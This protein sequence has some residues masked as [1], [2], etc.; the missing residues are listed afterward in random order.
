MAEST[1]KKHLVIIGG[2]FGGLNLAK[3]VDKSRW[4]V[5]L[6]DRNNYHSFP[7][8]FYQV[9]SSGL[10]PASISFPFRRELNGRNYEGCSF[11]MGTVE[12][13]DVNAKTV[14][15]QYETIPYDK[16]VI[17]AG[18]TNNFFGIE[19]LEKTVF[20]LKSTT[21]AIRARNEVLDRLERAAIIPDK[22]KRAHLLTFVV[23]GGGPA[24]V[25]I[26]GALGEMKRYVIKR[27]YLSIDPDE[28]KVVLVE[29]A[30]VLLQAMGPKAAEDALLGLRQLLVD[31]QLG[32]VMKSYKDGVVTFGDGSELRTDTVIW[33]AG[34]VGVS[35]KFEGAQPVM[36]RGQRFKVDNN[37]KV[38]G[39][40]DVYAIGD[41]AYM[42][43]PAYP[44]GHPQV[45][46]VALQQGACL[47]GNLSSPEGH[48]L[49]FVYHDKGSM[50]TI[51]RNRA[52]ANVGKMYLS[53]RVAWWAWLV[54]HLLSI[55]GMR[56]R[57]VVFINWMWNYFNFS[58]G[59]RLL[60]R[61]DRYPLRHYW[62][63][64]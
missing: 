59:L 50:A 28:V 49:P 18:S 4:Q 58:A 2:G 60:L 22:N 6:V 36:E 12:T 16:L 23:V 7:P 1:N 54:V 34:V 52:V 26:A 45:A 30:D 8:L 9:A 63:E 21:E 29:G 57:T 5:V 40:E 11:R 43:T 38:E 41:I 44:S 3:R 31:V 33:T 35:F 27:E 14:R 32:K 48:E 47:A 55:L 46:Q 15:T 25:E 37:C 62:S 20:T 64:E 13:I 17:A 39:L 10:E 51:G 24:G 61:P 53:G 42:T 56:N 19:N